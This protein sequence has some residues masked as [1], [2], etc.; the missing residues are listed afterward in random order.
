M[1][2][3]ALAYAYHKDHVMAKRK[4]KPEAKNGSKAG[5]TLQ[6]R[7]KEMLMPKTGLD[8]LLR[9]EDSVLALI[10][11]QGQCSVWSVRRR[12]SNL[13]VGI[14][15]DNLRKSGRNKMD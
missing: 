6:T 1:T 11:H 5:S 13:R 4:T 3:E 10:D 12:A 8:C 9:P 14:P 15:E 7:D 2:W